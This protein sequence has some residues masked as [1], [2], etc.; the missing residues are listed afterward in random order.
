MFTAIVSLFG[1]FLLIT[2]VPTTVS[3]DLAHVTFIGWNV[4]IMALLI[5]GIAL[6]M[7][8]YLRREL[9]PSRGEV[10]PISLF[11]ILWG[12]FTYFAATIYPSFL[13]LQP[14]PFWVYTEF[15]IWQIKGIFGMGTGVLL[16]TT[17]LLKRHAQQTQN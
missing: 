10:I 13:S 5:I 8:R 3:Q 11:A 14:L 17:S 12:A 6:N 1:T 16:A 7:R 2:L 15:W 4:S 9:Q